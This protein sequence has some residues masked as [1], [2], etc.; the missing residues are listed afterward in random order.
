MK[1]TNIVPNTWIEL[2]ELTAKYLGEAG[3]NAITPFQMETARGNVEI[4]VYV[5]AP[6]ELVKKII[7]ECKFWN[8]A[9]PKEKI[10]AFRTVV[11][12]SGAALGIIISKNGFQSGAIEAA[13]YS[14]ILLLNWNDFIKIIFDK[15]LLNKVAKLKT[16]SS[17][18]Y[19]YINEMHFPYEKLNAKE[20]VAYNIASAK[21]DKLRYTCSRISVNFLKNGGLNQDSFYGLD[22][23]STYE[24]YF[25]FLFGEVF[26]AKN[27]FE[28][29][30]R[31]SDVKFSK[32]DFEHADEMFKF[33]GN[34]F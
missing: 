10:H 25:N 32:A 31:Y 29:I 27:E 34:I 30:L 15:W 16:E 9:I 14:N 18:L 2:Q 20:R 12:D 13:K 17:P 7:I 19:L 5:E 4:D 6:D 8:T 26:C 33:L 3:Y 23:F 22:G 1:L 24:E 21:Y 11:N 28:E